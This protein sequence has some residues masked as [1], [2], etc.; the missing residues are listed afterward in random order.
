M[1]AA[2]DLTALKVAARGVLRN[3]HFWVLVGLLAILLFVYQAWPWS[4]RQLTHGFWRY[5]SWLSALRSLV[6]NVELKAHILGVLFFIPIIYGSVTLSWPGGLFAWLVSLVWLVPTLLSW[7]GSWDIANLVLLLLPPLLVAIVAAERRW[8]EGERRNFVERENERRA[9]V[10][11]L[12]DTQEAERRRIA[13]EIHDEAL[14][15]LLGIANRLD[16]LAIPS[17]GD[18]WAAEHRAVKQELLQ[19]MEDL[20]RLSMNLRPSVLDSFGLISGI[21]WMATNN[22][23]NGCRIRTRVRGETQKM[24]SLAE[25]TVFR[26]VQEAITNILRHADARN[27]TVTLEFERDQLML[28][29]EDDGAGFKPPEKLSQYAEKGRLGVIGMQQRILS[30]GGTMQLESAPGQGTKVVATIPYSISDDISKGHISA[31]PPSS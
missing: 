11:R 4:E 27:A 14:Q 16:S 21:R 6:V 22:S 12:V 28:A 31:C 25:I 23:R 3:P 9:Y 7:P 24:S 26:V 13:Q 29:I 18:E 10:L 1:V 5:F 20:R 17:M 2:I 30:A 15:T 8:R 19:S